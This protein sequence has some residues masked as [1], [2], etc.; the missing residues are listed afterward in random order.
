MEFS[1]KKQINKS[2]HFCSG[3]TVPS[4]EYLCTGYVGK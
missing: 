4:R 1:G 3:R 2:E